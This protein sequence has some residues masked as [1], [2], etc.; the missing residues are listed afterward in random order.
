MIQ[1]DNVSSQIT[2]AGN[3]PHAEVV[4]QLRLAAAFVAPN[5]IEADGSGGA[6]PNELL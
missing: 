3:R 5:V 2:L 6:V 4:T 1:K